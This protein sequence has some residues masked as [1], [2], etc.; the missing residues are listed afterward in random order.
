MIKASSSKQIAALVADLSSGH[1]ATRDAA[2]ARLTV[3]SGRAVEPLATFIASAAPP[4]ARI[5]ALRTLEAIADPH[6]RGAILHA[7]DDGDPAVAATAVAAAGVYLRGPHGPEALDRLTHAAL[8]RS[9]DGAVRAA[10]VRAVSSLGAATIAPLLKTLREDPHAVVR[11]MAQSATGA[12]TTHLEPATMLA[13]AA[14]GELPDDP[15]FLRH[16]I[17]TAGGSAALPDLLRVIEAVREREGREPPD[18]GERWRAVRAAAHL[19]LAKRGSRIA[20]YDLRES[21]ESGDP[22]Q[23][24]EFLA[25]LSAV[26]DASCLDAIAQAHTRARDG[27]W[28]EHLAGTFRAI[29]SR[30]GLTRRHAAIRKIEKRW[31]EI[32]TADASRAGGAG[33]T[34]GAGP[35]GGAGGAGRERKG[36]G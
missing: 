8:D 36:S 28:R 13:A 12:G 18:R 21:L 27:W 19:G 6:A 4:A 25:A 7:I 22:R 24:V 9:R 5:A 17:V 34:G 16:A 31:P 35:A 15:A 32:L 1:A 2:I 3:I 10:A 29:V 30:E 20:L 14:R 23:P 33:G 26:G 11:E